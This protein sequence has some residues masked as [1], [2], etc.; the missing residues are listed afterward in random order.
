MNII[1]ALKKY[2]SEIKYSETGKLN[3]LTKFEIIQK[4]QEKNIYK[5]ITNNKIAEYVFLLSF[6]LILC[7]FVA[8]IIS[9]VVGFMV[10]FLLTI[11]GFILLFLLEIITCYK[12]P[13]YL[14]KLFVYNK[15]NINNIQDIPV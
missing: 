10:A 15:D 8:I 14:Y 2:F 9:C 3:L 12:M 1:V 13:K 4:Y 5:C 6:G 7:I 11:F